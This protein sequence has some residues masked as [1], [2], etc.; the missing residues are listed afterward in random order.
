MRRFRPNIVLDGID[1]HDEDHIE[2]LDFDTDDGP[3]RLKLVK[4]CTRCTI[5]GVDP[6]TGEPGTLVGD[7]LAGYR[8]DP[9]VGGAVTFGMNAIVLD[10]VERVLRIGQ[11]G[12]ARF[13]FG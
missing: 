5:P 10:G 3:V 6:A 1:A 9:R 7:T 12:R 4:P 2:R 11:Q 8:S 13:A